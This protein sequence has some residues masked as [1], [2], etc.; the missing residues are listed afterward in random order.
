MSEILCYT[1]TYSPFSEADRNWPRP[2]TRISNKEIAERVISDRGR[3]KPWL[4]MDAIDSILNTRSDIQL[5]VGDGRSTESIRDGLKK[6]HETAG[7]Y[8]LELYPERMSQWLIFNDIIEKYAMADTKYFVYS[9]S[10]VIWQMDWVGEAIREFGAHPEYQILFP[11]VNN[12]DQNLPCQIAKGPRDLDTITPPYQEEA[13]APVLN[14][15]AMV[16]R[17]DFLR[18]FGGYPTIFRNCFS[19]S[20]FSTMCTAVGGEMRLVPRAWVHHYGTLDLWQETNGSPYH[21]TE[22]KM[23]FQDIMNKVQMAKGMGLLNVDFLKKT[24]YKQGDAY[25]GNNRLAG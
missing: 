25:G 21:Y 7:G 20:F 24:L 19:E 18:T 23:L 10:D 9:S 8:S 17:M 22:E 4:Y 3:A 13:K 16:F 15:Y 6:H 2:F 1:P 14:A 12:G 5:V 11:C